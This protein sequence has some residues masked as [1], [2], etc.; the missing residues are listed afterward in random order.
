MYVDTFSILLEENGTDCN[1]ILCGILMKNSVK[2]DKLMSV[3][4]SYSHHTPAFSRAVNIQKRRKK[5]V[6]IYGS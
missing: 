2:L 1:Y 5:G 6:E 3:M 4:I